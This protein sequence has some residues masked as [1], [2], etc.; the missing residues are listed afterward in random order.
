M[1]I[2]LKKY[3]QWLLIA[4]LSI[5][6]AL[7]VVTPITVKFYQGSFVTAHENFGGFQIAVEV[8]TAFIVQYFIAFGLLSL[9]LFGLVIWTI[10][11]LAS[12]LVTYFFVFLGKNIDAWVVND[13]FENIGG[14]TFEYLSIKTAVLALGL[15]IIF[16]FLARLTW[17]GRR[18]FN[19]KSFLILHSILILTI[20]LVAIFD[21]FTVKKIRYNYPPVSIFTS[22]FKYAKIKK[23]SDIKIRKS[24]SSEIIS[25]HKISY[26]ND[27]KP[28]TVVFI[29]GES[30]RNDYFYEML[31][32]KLKEEK[33]ITFFNEVYSC[34]TLTRKSIPCLLTNVKHSHWEDFPNSVNMIDVFKKLN[35]GTYWIDNQNLY[36]YF[37]STYSF[38]AKSSDVIIEG[39]FIS[40]DLGKSNRYDEF[41]LPYIKKAI[42][43]ETEAKKDKF[44]LIHLLGSHWNL[45]L[46]YPEEYAKFSPRCLVTKSVSDCSKEE[47]INSYKNSV[48]YSFKVLEDI[49]ELFSRENAVVFFTPDHGFSLQDEGRIG[50]GANNKPFEQISVPLFVWHSDQYKKENPDLLK[51]LLKNSHKKITHEYVFHSILGCSGVGADF[52]DEDL[53][54]CR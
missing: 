50:N 8:L 43:D 28:R 26:T 33:N 45:D 7:I 11:F 32:A 2:K 9:G 21:E 10:L 44:I 19:S 29:I 47:L 34:G 37:D 31:P 4:L 18:S 22:I 27:K 39:K 23:D 42:G 16:G 35:F 20:L 30:L 13:I 5:F 53:N 52:I 3:P 36:G 14:L 41:L 24:Q 40:A 25:R 6:A 51:N 54:L 17:S 38:L 15:T 46:R 12:L 48:V 1:S 49:L